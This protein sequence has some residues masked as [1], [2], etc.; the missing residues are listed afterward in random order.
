MRERHWMA[1]RNQ[2]GASLAALDSRDLAY[3]Q[4]ISF[5]EFP[6]RRT[7]SVRDLEYAFHPGQSVG[8]RLSGDIHHLYTAVVSNVAKFHFLL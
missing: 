7:V 6:Y 2:I 8:R 1:K 4:S 5:R 3:C